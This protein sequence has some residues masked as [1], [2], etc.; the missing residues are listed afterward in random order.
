M[1]FFTHMKGGRPTNSR[2]WTKKLAELADGQYLVKIESKKKRTNPQNSYLWGCVYEL[3]LV[4]FRDLGYSE[5][6]TTS[7]VHEVFKHL[8]LKRDV[9]SPDGELIT[10]ITRSTTELTT[11]E[12]NQYLESIWQFS[13]ENLNVNIPPPGGSENL[14]PSY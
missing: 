7:D 12:F 6:K 8:F 11:I 4:G 5:I 3:A 2:V 13:A 9:V 10:T 1:E 14:F